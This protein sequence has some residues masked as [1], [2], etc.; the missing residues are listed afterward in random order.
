MGVF[1]SY[2]HRES[3]LTTSLRNL[4]L[5][6]HY[7]LIL[8]L[9]FSKNFSTYNSVFIAF[10]RKG[11]H[12]HS[13]RSLCSPSF[14]QWGTHSR[15]STGTCGGANCIAPNPSV[16]ER[17]RP[18]EGA[19]HQHLRPSEKAPQDPYHPPPQPD[20]RPRACAGSSP[21]PG[22]WLIGCDG[23]SK[24]RCACALSP[25]GLDWCVALRIPRRR[26]PSYRSG[27][28]HPQSLECSLN[29]ITFS[30]PLLTGRSR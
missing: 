20:A 1:Q 10:A 27:K 16:G 12:P 2:F 14:E 26:S 25:R 30:T 3:T 13:S 9:L 4:P 28:A 8:L 18:S 23:S 29:S 19:K 17:A 5:P 7:S 21:D 15:C 6:H 11:R 24:W 22:A